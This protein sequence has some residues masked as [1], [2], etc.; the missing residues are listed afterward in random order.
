MKKTLVWITHSFR[1]DSRLT[2]SLSGPCTFVYYSPY[3][4]AGPREKAILANCSK[5]NLDA[6]YQ[7]LDFF[8]NQLSDKGHQ[9]H[10]FKEA[11]PISHINSLVDKYEFDQ[12]I[13]DL[14]LFGMWNTTDPME[15]KVPFTLI[16]S[17]LIDDECRNMTAKHR[18]MSH[19]RKI[20][21]EID[22]QWQPKCDLLGDLSKSC[23]YLFFN[24]H[25]ILWLSEKL[26]NRCLMS[27]LSGV[28]SAESVSGRISSCVSSCVNDFRSSSICR[29][30]VSE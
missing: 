5:E 11:D 15:I 22:Y 14:P 10:V 9:L 20:Y 19:T 27:E 7:S 2:N 1:L 3:Y 26:S 12:V 6:F 24:V 21:D 23:F 17:D 30:L 8:R 16:D 29:S 18:W 28:A 13:I 25:D 4:F